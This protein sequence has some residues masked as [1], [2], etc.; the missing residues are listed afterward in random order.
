MRLYHCKLSKKLFKFKYSICNLKRSID[1]NC[2]ATNEKEIL[3]S[4]RYNNSLV[5]HRNMINF[6]LINKMLN[7]IHIILC[8]V[9]EIKS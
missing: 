9:R 5:I 7:D 3:I 1:S 8:L 4:I 2:D 6:M